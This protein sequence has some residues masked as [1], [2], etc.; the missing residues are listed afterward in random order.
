MWLQNSYVDALALN[1][2]VFEGR[3][4]RKQLRLN[5]VL[6]VGP[7]KKGSLHTCSEKRPCKDKAAIHRPGRVLS[8]EVSCT[9]TL[10]LDLLACRALRKLTFII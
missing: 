8:P 2:T 3:V 9:G 7:Y 4:F 10:I 6:R 1:V 5:E